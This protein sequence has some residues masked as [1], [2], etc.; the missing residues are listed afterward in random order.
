MRY[1]VRGLHPPTS[2]GVIAPS[3]C[4]RPLIPPDAQNLD[5]PFPP[6]FGGERSRSHFLLITM[7]MWG[8]KSAC[9]AE[10]IPATPSAWAV[11]TNYR[12][13]SDGRR[14]P[15]ILS[16]G[17]FYLGGEIPIKPT[18][19][20]D[21]DCSSIVMCHICCHVQRDINSLLS[22]PYL[23]IPVAWL[24]GSYRRPVPWLAS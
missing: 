21:R 15:G 23:A 1:Q 17:V 6:A 8:I 20:T 2:A 7:Q 19:Q 4:K 3:P 11:I 10:L 9:W 12:Q 22:L 13:A 16:G 5:F 14:K 18:G 24:R